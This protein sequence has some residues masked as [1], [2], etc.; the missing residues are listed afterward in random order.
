MT[1]ISIGVFLF[2]LLS[3]SNA[4]HEHENGMCL[5]QY[6]S[7]FHVISDERTQR[8]LHNA[9]AE[10]KFRELKDQ[11]K[12]LE[13]KLNNITH[14][15]TSRKMD[16]SVIV[17]KFRQLE[18]KFKRLEEK[19]STGTSKPIPDNRQVAFSGTLSQPMLNS[20]F[21]QIVKF[22]AVTTNIGNAYD[23]ATG[24]FQCPVS[25]LYLI[26]TT[27]LGDKSSFVI[28]ETRQNGKLIA[29]SHSGIGGYGHKSGT[30]TSV[31]HAN[32]G[33][34]ISSKVAFGHADHLDHFSRFTAVLL[35]TD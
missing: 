28:L 11:N 17:T 12:I 7:L 29:R 22:N 34:K 13:E 25:G 32:K 3:G 14:E 20:E 30:D 23:V 18:N 8:L 6:L 26:S 16:D 21:G 5:S 27:V 31:I 10:R 9:E 35:K 19:L 1:Y 4:S 24:I 15:G 33:D 2:V